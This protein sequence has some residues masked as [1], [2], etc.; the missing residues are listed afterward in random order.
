MTPEIAEAE[1]PPI[2]SVSS[3]GIRI[4]KRDAA[5]ILTEREAAA[6]M[7]ELYDYFEK[8]VLRKRK[9]ASR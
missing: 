1:K 9:G 8:R 7:A 5:C 3:R 6:L 4:Q 2:L